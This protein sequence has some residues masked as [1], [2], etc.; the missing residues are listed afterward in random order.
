MA[1]ADASVFDILTRTTYPTAHAKKKEISQGIADVV[2]YYSENYQLPGRTSTN[3]PTTK[4]RETRTLLTGF[5]AL[6]EKL[7]FKIL[8]KFAIIPKSQMVEEK[9]R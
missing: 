1:N 4:L 6:T 5:E 2:D 8:V 9:L 3:T 7:A